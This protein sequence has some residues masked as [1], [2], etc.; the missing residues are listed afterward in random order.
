MS[1]H[2]DRP[3]PTTP[4]YATDMIKSYEEKLLGTPRES[5]IMGYIDIPLNYEELQTLSPEEREKKIIQRCNYLYQCKA[6]PVGI[7]YSMEACRKVGDAG[8]KKFTKS[9]TEPPIQMPQ[10]SVNSSLRY[11]N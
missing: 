1:S 9:K 6:Y 2:D 3:S 4:V 10:E 7:L 8:E 5:P 11:S